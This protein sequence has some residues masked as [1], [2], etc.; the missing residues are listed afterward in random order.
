MKA[1]FAQLI[2]GII[3]YFIFGLLMVYVVH[4][5][6]KG[7]WSFIV[8]WTLGMALAHTFIME[9]FRQRLTTGKDKLKK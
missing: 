2:A 9:P 8:V 7:N 5:S 4:G 3:I 1:K 6:L